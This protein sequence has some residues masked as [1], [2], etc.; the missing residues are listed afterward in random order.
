LNPLHVV[1]MHG[2]GDNVHQR[3]IVRELRKNR[4]VWLETPWPCL[5]HD[6]P[7]LTLISRGTRLR[8]QA[9]NLQREN[10]KFFKG[11]MP[12]G[13]EMLTV[14]YRSELV[15]TQG[16]VLGAMSATCRVPVGDF[17]LPVPDEWGAKAKSLVE[18]VRKPLM[19][20]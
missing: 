20:F 18:G 14:S 9:K 11:S 1:G 7:D 8:T 12:L 16:S 17:R 4:E 2:L 19:V 5:Y 13:M 15:R 3:A 6:M 10:A